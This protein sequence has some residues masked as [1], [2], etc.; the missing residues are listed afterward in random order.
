MKSDRQCTPRSR[1]EWRNWLKKNHEHE[2]RVRVI[3]YKK[4]TK[5]PSPSYQELMDEAICFGWIDTTINRI[6]DERYAIHFVKR[7]K[8]ARWS[9]NTRSY[10]KRLIKEKRMT[11]AGLKAYKGGLKWPTFD[12]N[13]PKNPRPSKELLKELSKNKAALENFNGFA[14]SYKRFYI[15]WIERA[16]RKETRDKRISQVVQRSA[17]NKKPNA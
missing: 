15:R 3:R 16:K 1:A 4:H 14:P 13:L 10:A 5:R 8:T 2:T 11:A 7:K 9:N 12:H 17:E 6:D